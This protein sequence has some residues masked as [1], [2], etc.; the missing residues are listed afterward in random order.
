[1]N[2]DVSEQG[3]LS[4]QTTRV[5]PGVKIATAHTWNVAPGLVGGRREW[6]HRLPLECA[7]V[8]LPGGST[9]QAGCHGATLPG[10]RGPPVRGCLSHTS[11]A[12]LSLCNFLFSPSSPETAP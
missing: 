10:S 7:Q 4:F 12:L 11:L 3:T 9:R 8:P 6:A 1:M 5:C 2:G